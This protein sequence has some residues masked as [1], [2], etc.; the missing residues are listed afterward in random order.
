VSGAVAMDPP[1]KIVYGLNGVKGSLEIMKAE[2][3][4]AVRSLSNAVDSPDNMFNKGLAQILDKEYSNAV[5]TFNEL[6]SKDSDYAMA[7]YGVAIAEARQGK[8]DAAIGAI[9]DAVQMDPGLKSQIA[10]DLEFDAMASSSGF[11]NAVK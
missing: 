7:A 10:S 11:I 1:S 6:M 5:I 4:A 2:Y 8:T 3:D 9:E